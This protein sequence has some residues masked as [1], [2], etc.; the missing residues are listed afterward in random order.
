MLDAIV[1]FLLEALYVSF[2]DMF[3]SQ[4]GQIRSAVCSKLNRVG[5]LYHKVDRFSNFSLSNIDDS[6]ECEFQLADL[7]L[8]CKKPCCIAFL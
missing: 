1:E 3:P 7:R 8:K 5:Q 2:V 6:N 4:D